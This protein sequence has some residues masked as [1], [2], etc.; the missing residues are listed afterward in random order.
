MTTPR[1]QRVVIHTRSE[2][3]TQ[4]AE[5][6]KPNKARKKK[7]PPPHSPE[8]R[9]GRRKRVETPQ[10]VEE[11]TQAEDLVRMDDILSN[12]V[13]TP[14]EVGTL[15]RVS[16][17]TV[18]QLVQDGDLPAMQVRRQT[19]V[20]RIDVLKFIHDLRDRDE[21]IRRYHESHDEERSSES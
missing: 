19:R 17:R 18:M 4:R 20:L 12:A 10:P 15:L 13:L 1:R 5:P 7:P 3:S 11:A 14:E 8:A 21:R 6:P 16:P 9:T 2:L